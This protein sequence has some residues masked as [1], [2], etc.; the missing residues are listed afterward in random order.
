MEREMD[1]G[2]GT[3]LFSYLVY[4]LHGRSPFIRNVHVYFFR[5]PCWLSLTFHVEWLSLTWAHP[6][7]QAKKVLIPSVLNHDT[8]QPQQKKKKK[9]T[10]QH[11]TLI[12]RKKE[13]RTLITTTSFRL[14]PHAPCMH[15]NKIYSTN[16]SSQSCMR[17][18]GEAMIAKWHP[19]HMQP[20]TTYQHQVP[21][22]PS[23]VNHSFCSCKSDPR[24]NHAVR[25]PRQISHGEKATSVARRSPWEPG[26]S[27]PSLR[28]M[29]MRS[30]PHLLPSFAQQHENSKGERANDWMVPVTCHRPPTVDSPPLLRYQDGAGDILCS[31]QTTGGSMHGAIICGALDL[32]RAV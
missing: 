8:I 30:H 10:I 15:Q 26:S 2:C 12:S 21:R 27:R 6:F 20:V 13:H 16:I 32:P 31:H 25:S 5:Y 3:I 24:P 14:Q 29:H 22:F 9:K 23:P 4:L 19:I 1:H 18:I 17:L 7:V 28:S 11:K